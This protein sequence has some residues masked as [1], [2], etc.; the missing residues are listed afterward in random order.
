MKPPAPSTSIAN[1]GFASQQIIEIMREFG[2]LHFGTT[3]LSATIEESLISAAIVIGMA[4]GKPMT[5]TDI[6]HY[7]GYPRPTVIRKL[8]IVAKH[9]RLATVKTG[10]RVCFVF[11]DMDDPKVVSGVA[12]LMEMISAMC[13][14]ASKLNPSAMDLNQGDR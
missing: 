7:L 10:S 9:R 8:K 13:H 2:R 3:S 11:E 12:K 1:R 14:Q 5:A 6:G 4:D